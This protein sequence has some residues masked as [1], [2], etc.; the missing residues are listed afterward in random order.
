MEGWTPRPSFGSLPRDTVLLD[1]ADLGRV[2][3]APGGHVRRGRR[4]AVVLIAVALVLGGAACTAGGATDA[5]T[6]T[7]ATTARLHADRPALILGHRGAAGYRPEETLAA[8]E[9]GVRMGADLIELDLVSTK[10][11]VLVARHE[12]E[13]SGTTDVADHP[14]FASRRTTKTIDG[15]TQKGWFTED[16]TLAELRTLRAK[17]RIPQVRPGNAQ[18]DGR[19]PIATFD[20]VLALRARLSTELK[21][22]VGVAPETKHPSYFRSIGLPLEEPM[23]ASLRRAGLGASGPSGTGPLV[24]IQS[25]E[26]GN[27]LALRAEGAP[28]RTLFLVNTTGS[29]ATQVAGAPQDYEGFTTH[30]G[31]DY[32][33]GKVDIIGPAQDLVIPQTFT[34]A[35]GSPTDLVATAHA[36]G[37]EVMPWTFRAENQFLPSDYWVGTNLTSPGN[38]QQLQEVFLQAGVDGLFTDQPDITALARAAVAG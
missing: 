6:A 4:L 16:F 17:E 36:D 5:P 31:L 8:D 26:L 1:E 25:F 27:L 37:L 22:P 11:H 3:T 18:Y 28:V 32:L 2:L 12:N 35:L 10:D 21:R 14:E 24:I 29:P 9:T 33:R 34:G 23:L 19:F 38:A 13:I 20:E 15:T 30:D 7:R